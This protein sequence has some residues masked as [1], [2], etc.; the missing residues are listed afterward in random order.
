MLKMTHR[1]IKCTDIPKFMVQWERNSG[2]SHGVV[3]H[4]QWWDI[5]EEITFR[6]KV[7]K[8]WSPGKNRMQKNNTL[9]FHGNCNE[10]ICGLEAYVSHT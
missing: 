2:D 1:V 3:T 6:A 8:K 9:A 4:C 10:H 7:Q 5:S